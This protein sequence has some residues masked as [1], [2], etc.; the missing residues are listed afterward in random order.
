MVTRVREAPTAR[1]TE[2]RASG[3][4]NWRGERLEP[5]TT[6]VVLTTSVASPTDIVIPGKII[7]L[8]VS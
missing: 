8:L 5:G 3:P 6:A 4:V 7:F 1:R 2:R